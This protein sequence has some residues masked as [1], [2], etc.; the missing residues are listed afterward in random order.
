MSTFKT[1]MQSGYWNA[2]TTRFKISLATFQLGKGSG[3][4]E[5]PLTWEVRDLGLLP[6]SC[7]PVSERFHF[8]AHENDKL[9]QGARMIMS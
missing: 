5:D 1:E 9:H 4:V 8:R 7:L 2:C 3:V 6:V